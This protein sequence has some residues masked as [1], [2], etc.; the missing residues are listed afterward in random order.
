MADQFC[1][2][3]HSVIF[4]IL[5]FFSFPL[6]TISVPMRLLVCTIGP[7]YMK[8]LEA[9]IQSTQVEHFAKNKKKCYIV[10]VE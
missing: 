2:Y 5:L 9:Q 7:P 6:K 4:F 1:I 3:R 8:V 10:A